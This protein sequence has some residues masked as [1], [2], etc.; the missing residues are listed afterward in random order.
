MIGLKADAGDNFK[1]GRQYPSH[2]VLFTRYRQNTKNFVKIQQFLLNFPKVAKISCH[3]F[4][5]R[6]MFSGLL[7]EVFA[8][9]ET[10]NI[11]FLTP[12]KRST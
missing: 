2:P 11:I 6:S 7:Y 9:S 4:N 5:I 10:Q 3:E 8:C 12:G 1:I